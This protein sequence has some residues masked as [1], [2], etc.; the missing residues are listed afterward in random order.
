VKNSPT[1]KTMEWLGLIGVAITYTATIIVFVFMIFQTK[2]E[3][4]EQ[5]EDLKGA[6]SRVDGMVSKIYEDRFHEQ[7]KPRR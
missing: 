5:K 1:L 2:T 6:I 7:W 3:G 4:A